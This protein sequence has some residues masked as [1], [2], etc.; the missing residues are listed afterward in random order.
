MFSNFG[1]TN[2]QLKSL[3]FSE[4]QQKIKVH[5]ADCSVRD[6]WHVLPCYHNRRLQLFRA[7]DNVVI[8]GGMSAMLA[9]FKATKMQSLSVYH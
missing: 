1:G 8:R 9:Y 5:F 4:N 6:H 3:K 7:C 2:L